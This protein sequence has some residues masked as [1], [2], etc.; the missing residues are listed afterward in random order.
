MLVFLLASGGCAGLSKKYGY[1]SPCADAIERA[2]K[3]RIEGDLAGAHQS[4]EQMQGE[5]RSA[6]C[7]SQWYNEKARLHFVE[8]QTELAI[9]SGRQARDIARRGGVGVEAMYAAQ[10]LGLTQDTEFEGRPWEQVAYD[11]AQRLHPSDCDDEC[12]IGLLNNLAWKRLDQA[13]YQ[14]AYAHFSDLEDLSKKENADVALTQAKYGKALCALEF[15]QIEGIRQLE[16]LERSL[17]YG[18]PILD[19]VLEMLTEIYLQQ[20]KTQK[21]ASTL[22][23]WMVQL[24]KMS[25]KA[26]LKH[27]MERYDVLARAIENAHSTP[28]RAAQRKPASR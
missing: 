9:Q 25:G 19:P 28:S 27:R 16:W 7:Q 21:A 2:E 1:Q 4:L 26:H 11:E 14:L 24:Q 3:K 20:G 18:E 12:Q 23:K 13:R 15:D 10:I 22:D 5:L 8:G 6:E 17:S